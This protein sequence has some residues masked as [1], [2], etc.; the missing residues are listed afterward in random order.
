MN[1]RTDRKTDS[2]RQKVRQRQ[3]VYSVYAIECSFFLGLFPLSLGLRSM[4]LYMGHIKSVACTM[5]HPPI[6]LPAPQSSLYRFGI[7]NQAV[8]KCSTWITCFTLLCAVLLTID[9]MFSKA[10][11][12]E[13]SDDTAVDITL[14]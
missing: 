5:S 11:H 14:R 13:V 3:T 10:V 4:D 2:D 12:V 8:K 1:R 6:M 7:R 9:A